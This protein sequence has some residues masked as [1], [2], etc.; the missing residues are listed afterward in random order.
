MKS[1]RKIACLGL[2][3]GFLAVV[4]GVHPAF[5][6]TRV[7]VLP[8]EGPAA[9][10]I[11]GAIGP[12]LPG[13]YAL[14]PLAQL[15]RSMQQGGRLRGSEGYAGLA[16][17]LHAAAL[18]GGKV[19]RDNRWHLRLYVRHGNSGAV[20]G[21][22]VWS[23]ASPK[24]LVDSV[25]WGASYWLQSML[26]GAEAG[27]GM[28]VR[29]AAF[30]QE[31]RGSGNDEPPAITQSRST[32]RSPGSARP[33]TATEGAA[34]QARPPAWEV[35]LGPRVLTRTFTYVDNI[36]GLPGYT[37]SGAPAIVGQL[38]LYPLMFRA[39]FYR[40]F[41]FAG[42]F[43]TSIGA[44]TGDRA[45][46]AAH[47]TTLL[48]YRAGPRYRMTS[49]NFTVALGLDYGVHSFDMDG[50]NM[51][52]NVRYSVLRPSIAGRSELARGLSL[53][54]T[55]AYLHVLSVGDLDDKTKFPRVTAVGAELGIGVGYSIDRDF[56]VRL[57]ADLRHY[58]HSMHVQVG[59]PLIVGGALDEHFGAA[60]LI[61][62]RLR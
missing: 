59:D 48:A 24:D 51:A 61:S 38:E 36:S 43:E 55:A 53:M 16:H 2:C 21:T 1:N 46:A 14:V 35:S 56:E 31:V 30:R 54:V 15:R 28:Q 6:S 45:G 42:Y 23:G 40:N 13:D 3:A 4:A 58:A 44:K 10:Q 22:V 5:A 32:A 25:R 17:R 18:I 33:A 19:T 8:F 9:D 27:P 41:G 47:A 57:V 39:D 60:L 52:P 49:D 29:E 37:L 34:V 50:E 26:A 11:Q 12:A 20:A 62:Y 7:I